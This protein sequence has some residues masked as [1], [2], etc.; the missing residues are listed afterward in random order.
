MA[1]E[2]SLHLPPLGAHDQ[3]IHN[4]LLYMDRLHG[5]V[6]VANGYGRVLT[7][8]SQREI[9]LATDGT[10]LNRDGSVPAVL[11]QY[12]RHIDLAPNLLAS[13]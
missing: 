9:E 7:M 12:D 5:P 3:A 10:V 1:G 8:G 2:V 4:W 13:F 11:H 6:A